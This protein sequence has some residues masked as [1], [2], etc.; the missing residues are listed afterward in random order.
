MSESNFISSDQRT[1]HH[2]TRE[3]GAVCGTQINGQWATVDAEDE[4]EAV[5]KYNL[6]PCVRCMDRHYRL[7]LWR[8]D[9]HSSQIMHGTDAPERW[10]E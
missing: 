3:G 7:E 9:V 4:E 8:K 6:R 5:M 10:Q 2:G 1:V